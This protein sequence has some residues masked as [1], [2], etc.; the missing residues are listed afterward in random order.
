MKI[1]LIALLIVVAFAGCLKG[2]NDNNFTCNYN[3][4]GLVAPASEIDSVKSYLATHGLI[5]SQHCSGAFFSIDQ[6][7]TG[8]TPTACSNIAFTYEGRLTNGNVFDSSL[9]TPIVGPLSGL[10]T[11]VKLGFLKLKAGGRMHMYIPPTLGYGSTPVTGVPANSMLI[12][13]VK[14]VAVQ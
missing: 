7:G 5:A 8:A 10:I 12:F 14:L 13:D 4:C 2:S 11:G 3:E 6:P 9:T 1:V